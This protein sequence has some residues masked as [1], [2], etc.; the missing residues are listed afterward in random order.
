MST[1]NIGI[2]YTPDPSVP[3]NTLD[4]SVSPQAKLICQHQDKSTEPYSREDLNDMKTALNRAGL[5]KDT[6]EAI[7]EPHKSYLKRL[8]GKDSLSNRIV[9]QAFES[10]GMADFLNRYKDLIRFYCTHTRE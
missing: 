5:F 8:Y 1:K 7:K 6:N 4:F 3:C 10:L 2:R 9:N